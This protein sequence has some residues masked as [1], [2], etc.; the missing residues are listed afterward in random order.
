MTATT[1]ITL[2][3][4]PKD[5]IEI[6]CVEKFSDGSGYASRLAVGS[7]PFSCADYHFFFDN[8]PRFIKDIA[9]AYERVG[10]KARLGHTYEK[11]FIEI[12]VN[13]DGHVAVSGLMIQCGPPGQE[14][15]FNFACDQT[16]LPELLRSLD[17]A[18]KELEG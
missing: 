11:D 15:R 9:K 1:P 5:F 16:F 7:W 13:G 3:V 18:S 10:G 8:L 17:Q 12:E 2:R 6:S 4:S 14:L